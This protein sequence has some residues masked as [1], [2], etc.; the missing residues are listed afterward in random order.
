MRGR[1]SPGGNGLARAFAESAIFERGI[2]PKNLILKNRGKMRT[3][4]ENGKTQIS[5]PK[6]N[7]FGGEKTEAIFLN[8]SSELIGVYLWFL[9]FSNILLKLVQ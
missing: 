6:N 9:R 3:R 2:N 5:S 4:E 7:F 1:L 8:L